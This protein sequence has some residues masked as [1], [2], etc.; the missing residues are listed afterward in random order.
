MPPTTFRINACL[1][2]VLICLTVCFLGAYQEK[3]TVEEARS[4]TEAVS[5]TSQVDG[6]IAA[7]TQEAGDAKQNE[8][9]KKGKVHYTKEEKLQQRIKKL[10]QRLALIERVLFST[11][12]LD[13]TRAERELAEAKLKLKNSQ[14][15]H[16]R[17]YVSQLQLEYDQ[18]EV[19]R[20]Q[21]EL[22]LATSTINLKQKASELDVLEAEYQL[23]VARDR[24]DTRT[25]LSRKGYVTREQVV[26][27]QKAV[28]VAEQKLQHAKEKLKVAT[29]L[30]ALDQG[31]K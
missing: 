26:Q 27:C 25:S 12:K 6:S 18:V 3:Q 31:K 19:D 15:L 30:D 20:A 23:K 13:T 9:K 22:E 29:Q 24:L 8:A 21:R 2:F 28:E 11:S 14:S 10:E 1:S 7:G 16:A 5:Q 4:Q 17:G